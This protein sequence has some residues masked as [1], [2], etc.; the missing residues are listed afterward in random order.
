[1]NIQDLMQSGGF[2]DTAPVRKDIEW[3]GGDGQKSQGHLWIVRQSFGALEGFSGKADPDRSQG[4][5]MIS[6][7]VRLG[8]TE[9]QE[10]L[11][12]E[13]AYNLLPTLA[14]AMIVAINEVNVP[15]NSQPPTSS[16]MS[17]SSPASA[18][19]QLRKPKRTSAMKKS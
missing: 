4:A 14:W 7:S 9:P 5:K 8:D 11:S 13:Q 10:Q 18:A 19:G 16:S 15:K 12:Y 6:L 3:I 2:V 17:L 1:M